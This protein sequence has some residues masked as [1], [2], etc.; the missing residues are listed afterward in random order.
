M[1]HPDDLVVL[2][3][4]PPPRPTTNPYITQLSQVLSRT[5]GLALRHF[6]Y[7]AALTSRYDV[8]HTHWPENLVGGHHWYGR[9]ARRALAVLL[10]LRLWALRVPVVRTWHN[11]ERPSDLGRIDQWLL[12]GFDRLTALRIVLN[13]V[14]EQISSSPV[15]TILHGHYRDWYGHHH[16]PPATPG[17][18][19]YVGLI[20][21]YKGV[22]DLL[23]AFA[24]IDDPAA[25]L[26]VVGKP[27]TPEL[28][29]TIR[30][31]ARE[32]PRMSVRLEFVDDA[33]YA[34]ELASMSLVAMPYRHMH[35]SGVALAAL[36][37]GRPVLM[38]DNPVNRAL[39]E[40]VGHRW[41]HLFTGVV[42]EHDVS[43]ALAAA[44]T[45]APTDRPDL[46]RRDWD[47]AGT[48]H[49]VAFAAATS[50]EGKRR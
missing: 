24:R 16:Q 2:E 4:F 40:E 42:D 27:S 25:S 8:F 23:A 21:R 26:R 13:P 31:L 34:A 14:T 3:S 46:S 32:D 39:A 7:R 28:E 15:V 45:L 49:L 44:S 29:E 11:L 22:E 5:S 20:R 48:A 43:A 18:V 17:R 9:V 36:S 1:T 19:G 37:V 41:V 6:S 35:N 12:D 30:T 33:D 38:P 10:L 50:R 47:D